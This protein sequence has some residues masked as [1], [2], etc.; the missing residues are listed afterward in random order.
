MRARYTI[1]LARPHDH[2]IGVELALEGVLPGPLHVLMPEWIPGH[3]ALMNNARFVQDLRAFANGREVAS[4]KTDKQRW[5]IDTGGARRVAVRYDVYA[6]TL[7]SSACFFD[8]TQCHVNGGNAF[9]YVEGRQDLPSE[10]SISDRPRGWEVATSLA[11]AGPNR[12]TAPTYDDLIDSPVKVGRFHHERFRVR[13]KE[14]HVVLSDLGDTV[15]NLPR[16]VK[17]T[18]AFVE[19]F[20]GV[21]GGLPYESYWFLYDLHP[22]RCRGGAL[23]HK[24]STHLALPL[25]L[26]SADPDDYETILVVA[27][28]EYFHLWNVKRIRPRP[29]GPFDYTREQHTTDLWVAEGLTDYY[30]WYGLRRSGV[31]SPKDYLTH[32]GRY[33]D[34]VHDMPG[35]EAMTLREASWESWTQSFWTAR[36][37]FEETNTLNRYVNYYTKGAVVG[38]LLDVEIRAATDG[39]RGLEDVFRALWRGVSPDE[40]YEPGAFEDAV[41]RVAGR[42]VR[43]LLERWVGTTAPLDYRRTFAKAGLAF[44]LAT[45]TRDEDAHKRRRKILGSV[46]L[47]IDDR[48]EFPAVV[49]ATPGSPAAEAGL[50]RGDLLLA[51]DG[52]RLGK[53]HWRRLLQ[54]RPQGKPFEV[55][56]FRYDRLRSARVA[57]R[58]DARK[59]ARFADL[60]RPGKAAAR[61]RR[62]WLGSAKPLESPPGARRT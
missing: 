23:E 4:R 59:T 27:C 54:E 44:S 58:P 21:F 17:E 41:E 48:G 26:D 33:V 7:S 20:A 37:S 57:P 19:W 28:H 43:R 30:A 39:R 55:S 5:E 14:H 9:L 40:G 31:M 22:T 8:D 1:S 34:S 49:N 46:G 29:L 50:G 12:W 51:V 45:P 52:E 53:D 10:L 11:K 60:P 16:L 13:G 61:V 15:E 32:L 38:A 35:R 62:R 24:S 18:K 6:H 3:Y 42:P 47:E 36:Q 2:L 25:R 56:F